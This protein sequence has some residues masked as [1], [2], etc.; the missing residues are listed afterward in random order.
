MKGLQERVQ[1]MSDQV[2]EKW[3]SLT[4]KQKVAIGLSGVLILCIIV[5]SAFLLKPKYKMLFSDK[6]EATVIAKVADVLDEN[7][8][9]YRIVN[10]STNIEV[11]EKQYEKAKM[12]TASSGA[13]ETGMTLEELLTN[14]MSV[15]STQYNTKTKEYSREVLQNTLKLIEGVEDARVELVIPEQK[16]AYLQS[17]TESRASVFLTLSKQLSSQQCEGI[18]TYVASSVE[19]LDRK[20]IVILD[21]TGTTLYSGEDES[22]TALGKQQELKNSAEG[23]IKAKVIELLGNMYAEVRISPNLV[24]DF[25][26][27]REDNIKYATQGEDDVRG[28]VASETEVKSSTTNGAAGGAPGFDSNGADTPTYQTQNSGTQQSKDSQNEIVYSPD[29]QETTYIK[30]LGDVDLEKSSLSVNLFNHKIYKEEEVTPNLGGITWSAYKEQHKDQKVLQ[31]DEAIVASIRNATGIENVV[32]NA[33]ENPIFLDQEEYVIDYKDFIPYIL[34][35]A[36]LILIAFIILKF[37]KQEEVVEVEPELEVEEML[38]TAKEQVT[39]DEIEVK[40]NLE[41]KRQID[42]FVE[43]KPEAVASLLKNWLADEDWE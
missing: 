3:E 7:G 32:V 29:K 22:I 41:T 40:E 5:L 38:K 27:Y 25:D 26:Q 12:Y 16:N 34:L 21:S 1:Q 43:E 23:Q 33:Y 11:Q 10:D 14:D 36:L 2:T 37:R 17:Q 28:I 15:T 31:V 18:A 20:N 24:L 30:N 6:A 4:K 13:T 8:I 19:N 35:V 9:S 42:K 39:L